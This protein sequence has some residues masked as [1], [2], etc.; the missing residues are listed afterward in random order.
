MCFKKQQQQQQLRMNY[1]LIVE[2]VEN[3]NK[4]K[5]KF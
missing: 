1:R 4:Q 3:T 2:K 5:R